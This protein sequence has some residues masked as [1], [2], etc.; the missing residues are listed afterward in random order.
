M[1]Q[2]TYLRK[3]NRIL[4]GA[5]V[6]KIAVVL[7]EDN[8]TLQITFRLATGGELRTEIWADEEGNGPG[9]LVFTNYEEKETA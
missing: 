3:T 6:K 9:A 4:L 5:T 1:N 2:A 7:M 8:P